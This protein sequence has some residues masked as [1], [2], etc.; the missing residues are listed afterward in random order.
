MHA[1]NAAAGASRL[2]KLRLSGLVQADEEFLSS[3]LAGVEVL[4]S[5]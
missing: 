5:E 1:A 3:P 4:D 2:C